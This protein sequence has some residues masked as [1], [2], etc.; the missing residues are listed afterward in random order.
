VTLPTAARR[1][2]PSDLLAAF[3]ATGIVFIVSLAIVWLGLTL[4]HGAS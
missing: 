2:R 1:L 4:A 3:F